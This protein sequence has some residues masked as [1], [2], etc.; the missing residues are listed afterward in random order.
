MSIWEKTGPG[1]ISS[2]GQLL[3]HKGK[4]LSRGKEARISCLKLNPLCLMQI[5]LGYELRY[6][7]TEAFRIMREHGLLSVK[8]DH[9][10]LHPEA[11]EWSFASSNFRLC[12]S[13]S[14]PLSDGQSLV[15]QPCH[16]GTTHSWP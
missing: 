1:S 7:T 5:I 15:P 10:K 16:C 9:D 12:L 8:V 4:S 2:C 14:F 11:S 13:Q 6:G 3:L